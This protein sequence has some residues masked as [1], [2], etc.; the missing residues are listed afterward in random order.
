MPT[1]RD[2]SEAGGAFLPLEPDEVL[3]LQAKQV[4]KRGVS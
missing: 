1:R 3:S 4:K 2:V